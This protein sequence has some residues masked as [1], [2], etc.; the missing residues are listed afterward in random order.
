MS[1]FTLQMPTFVR[2]RLA[3]L[4]LL[5]WAALLSSCGGGTS[6][7]QAFVPSRLI[8]FGDESSVITPAGHKYTINAF[9]PD[10]ST[11]DCNASPIWTQVVAAAYGFGFA[12]CPLS[13]GLEKAYVRARAEAR[14]EDFALQVDA[15]V[16]AGGFLETDLVTVL[17]G[18]NDVMD[19]YR[20]YPSKTRD[21]V[22]ALARQ[23]GEMVAAQV[24]RLVKL[25]AKVVVSTVPDLGLSPYGQAQG[26]AG[27]ALLSDLVF[28][29]N[30]RIRV[31]ILN[32]GRYIG[33]VLADEFIQ[34]A[35]KA[36]AYFGLTDASTAACRTPLPECTTNDLSNQALA[37]E[38]WLWASDR[39]LGTG[40]HRQLGTLALARARGNPF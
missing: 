36:P 15:Q 4:V 35:V 12:E 3:S 9:G 32:D 14:V 25:G 34:T 17:V 2:R 11:L 16:G 28:A 30:G 27:A 31:N 39:W 18:A 40:G 22:I 10:A 7:I 8:A 19:L 23:R 29:M 1:R 24:N 26:T 21:E 5:T 38:A 6:Q 13:T 20:Q 37:K 33:L